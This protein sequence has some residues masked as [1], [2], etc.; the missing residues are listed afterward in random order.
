MNYN[1]MPEYR[2]KSLEMGKCERDRVQVGLNLL[3]F[4]RELIAFNNFFFYLFFY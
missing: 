1:N 2:R 4:K 3:I